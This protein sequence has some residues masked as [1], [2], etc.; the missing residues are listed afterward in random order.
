[1]IKIIGI[2]SSPRY[3]G[4]TSTLVRQALKG[5]E[6]NGVE[7]EEIFLANYNLEFCRGCF[8]CLERGKCFINDDLEY[9]RKKLI[10]AN[11]I[12]IGSPT[13]GLEPNAI[14]KNF[15]ER[16][17]L[18]A[19]YTSLL[20]D[21]YVVGISTTGAVGARKVA[22]KLTDI[23]GGFIKMGYISGTMGVALDWDRVQNYPQYMEKAY[24]LGNSL[25]EDIKKGKKYRT[26]RL[27][28]KLLN[29]LFLKRTMRDNILK[30]K[31]T[32]MKGVYH[33][34]VEQGEIK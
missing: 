10:E 24:F 17:G 11:G 20:G 1:M 27:F 3:R 28:K 9:L 34:L 19:A 13:Y 7:V 29:K 33:Y 30:H 21:K 32:R 14:M 5:A 12:I 31:E 4:N 6:N 25:V 23:T 18:F 2:I 22:K 15:V 16:I 8:G 26:Q